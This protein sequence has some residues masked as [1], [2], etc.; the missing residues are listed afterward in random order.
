MA[1]AHKFCNRCNRKHAAPT[2]KRKCR[3]PLPTDDFVDDNSFDTLVD[4][5]EDV[6]GA[7]SDGASALVSEPQ[8]APPDVQAD[9]LTQ[10][11]SVVSLLAGKVEAT[12]QQVAVLQADRQSLHR[13]QG[14]IPRTQRTGDQASAPPPGASMPQLD[15]LRSDAMLSAQAASLVDSLDPGVSG[16][17]S[18][19]N[20]NSSNSN[21]SNSNGSTKRGWARPGGGTMPLKYAPPGPRILWSVMAGAIDFFSMTLTCSNSYK[22]VSR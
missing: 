14:A 15:S 1:P 18:S 3:L 19:V 6:V 5:D 16:S 9:T 10:I 11:L 13:S 2:G 21:S 12:Q 8:A 20:S 17:K 22:D 7:T 4:V